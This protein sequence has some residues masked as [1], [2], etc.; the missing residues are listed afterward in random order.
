VTRLPNALSS[1]RI[2]AVPILLALAWY[3]A[4]D[5]FLALFGLGLASDVLDGRLARSLGCES[6]FGARLDQWG[7]FALW[8]VLPLSAWWL[9]PDIIA[10][11]AGFVVLALVC[12]MLPTMLAYAKYRAVPGYHTWSVKIGSVLM[13]IGAALLLIFDLAWPFRIA[14]S[15]Q[16]VCALDEM[17]IT[18]LLSECRHDVPSV[19][20][21]L[22]LRRD[23]VA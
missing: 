5:L 22:R 4:T 20:H 7:D 11:E 3:G 8:G 15:F 16:L 9:W 6:D 2:L 19:F 23:G 10:R 12:M 13:A 1:F 17:G 14:A 21:A 18:M